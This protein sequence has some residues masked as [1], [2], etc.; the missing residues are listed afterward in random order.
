LSILRGDILC[1]LLSFSDV[2]TQGGDQLLPLILKGTFALQNNDEIK[3]KP[4]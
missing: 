1:Y 4:Y 2:L 3:K